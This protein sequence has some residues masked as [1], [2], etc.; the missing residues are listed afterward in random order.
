MIFTIRV[1]G[2]NLKRTIDYENE[3]TDTIQQRQSRLKLYRKSLKPWKYKV[4]E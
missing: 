2:S 3:N 1:P 4:A